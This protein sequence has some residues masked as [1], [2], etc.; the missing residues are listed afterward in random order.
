MGHRVH[1]RMND[2]NSTGIKQDRFRNSR[3]ESNENGNYNNHYGGV[4]RADA[5]TI[6]G[7]WAEN[8][9]RR[10]D[11]DWRQETPF[12]NGKLDNWNHRQGWDE[13]YE[14]RGRDDSGNFTGKGPRG[15]IRLDTRIHDDVCDVLTRD[16]NVDAGE[17]DVNVEGGV[18]T[19]TGKVED[20][21]MKR[22]AGQIIENL[23]GVKDVH[24]LLEFDRR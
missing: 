22:Y 24:N 21:N 20:R 7:A 9:G 2:G 16:R 17:V 1:K 5:N 23:S 4:T 8:R 14:S 3:F 12:E 6:G 18:V 15:Y 11:M 13:Y 10:G 19:L